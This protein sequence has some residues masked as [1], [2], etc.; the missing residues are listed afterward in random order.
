MRLSAGGP[1]TPRLG[2]G[3]R[4]RCAHSPAAGLLPTCGETRVGTGRVRAPPAASHARR[5]LGRGRPARSRLHRRN[6]GPSGEGGLLTPARPRAECLRGEPRARSS[7]RPHARRGPRPPA[8]R[9]V[10]RGRG[11]AWHRP[12]AGRGRSGLAG[13]ADRQRDRQRQTGA[14]AGRGGARRACPGDSPQQRYVNAEGWRWCDYSLAR[15]TAAGFGW[16]Y[17]ATTRKRR[18]NAWWPWLTLCDPAQGPRPPRARP[19]A[20]LQPARREDPSPDSRLG[21]PVVRLPLPKTW[22]RSPSTWIPPILA[23]PAA[24]PE[25]P[26][27]IQPRIYKRRTRQSGSGLAAP[28]APCLPRL[29]ETPRPPAASDP[30]LP[31]AARSGV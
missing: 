2:L 10:G 18:L 29:P 19:A 24:V 20:G 28:E 7:P 16:N 3:S 1:S 30:G 21:L 9:A 15:L 23:W 8:G 27:P 22:L 17:S 11:P 12:L 26:T 14:R 31:R 6:R 4:G 5:A 25:T 13:A